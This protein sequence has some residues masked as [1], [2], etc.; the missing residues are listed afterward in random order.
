MS[1]HQA[2]ILPQKGGPLAIVQRPTPSPGPNELLI[3]VHAVALNPVDIH[4]RDKGVF[5]EAYPAV[6]G[7]DVSGIVAETGSAVS[8]PK[9]TRVTAFASAFL[10]KGDPN[11]GAL[12]KY[13]L[14]SSEMVTVLPDRFSFIE[15]S[16]FPMAA[17]TTWNGWLWAGVAREMTMAKEGILVWGGSSSMG[18][19][20]IQGAKVSGYTVYATASSQH[21][22]YLKGLGASRVFDYK[23]EDV[24]SEIVNAARE[25]GLVFKIGYHATGSQQLSVDVLDA[26]RGGEKVKLAIA[27]IVD[28]TVKVP[29]GVETAFVMPP[30]D[31]EERKERCAWIFKSWLE[32]KLSAGQLVPSPRIQVVEGGLESA[33]KALDELK[34]GVSGVKLVLEL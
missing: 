1:S 11:Y 6:V 25:D 33:N 12:Q 16:V 30:E 17:L 29:E 10:R 7:S 24:L 31:P 27:P 34:A 15:G 2:A 4:Q 3:E 18:A 22:E 28:T 19:F 21:H 23:S 20:A 32:E 14:V 26:L 8:T 13:V 5:V 9:G